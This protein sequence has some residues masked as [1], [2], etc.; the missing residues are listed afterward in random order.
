MNE[1]GLILICNKVKLSEVRKTK[2]S[3]KISILVVS[4]TPI[5]S[6]VTTTDPGNFP[7]SILL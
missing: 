1:S 3:K 4:S 2:L 7:F 5:S 6:I